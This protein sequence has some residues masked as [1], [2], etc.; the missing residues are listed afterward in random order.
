MT[1]LEPE[2]FKSRLEQG[3]RDVEQFMDIMEEVELKYKAFLYANSTTF[4]QYFGHF[5]AH[6]CLTNQIAEVSEKRAKSKR[7]NKRA[8][9][10]L[11]LDEMQTKLASH[12]KALARLQARMNVQMNDSGKW[13]TSARSGLAHTEAVDDAVDPE[14]GQGKNAKGEADV[15]TRADD[16][17][18]QENRDADEKERLQTEEE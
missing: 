11:Q 8:K 15:L 6:F 4:N 3:D 14:I 2:E 17:F 10:R 18:F 13:D 5:K 12:E 16:K 1:G 9:Y 7:N